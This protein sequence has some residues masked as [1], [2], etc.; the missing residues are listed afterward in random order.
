MQGS[1]SPLPAAQ[2]V[3]LVLNLRGEVRLVLN[4]RG[5]VRLVIIEVEGY[6]S[7]MTQNGV[8]AEQQ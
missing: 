5:E 6:F 8:L 1:I 3:R 7:L 2:L 4:L